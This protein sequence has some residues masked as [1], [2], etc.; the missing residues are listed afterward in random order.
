MCPLSALSDTYY[1]HLQLHLTGK[2]LVRMVKEIKFP[3]GSYSQ[4][5]HAHIVV[6]VIVIQGTH[7]VTFKPAPE[8]WKIDSLG[9]PSLLH[10]FD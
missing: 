2:K 5:M 3:Q 9:D 7:K 4:Q 1:Y 10:S 8:G 6:V